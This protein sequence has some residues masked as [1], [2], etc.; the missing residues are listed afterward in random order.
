MKSFVS[1][2]LARAAA[3]A[4]AA[5]LSFIANV[6][7]SIPLL[8]IG[9]FGLR[10]TASAPKRRDRSLSGPLAVFMLSLVLVGI[11]SIFYHLSPSPDRLFWDRLPIAICLAAFACAAAN[12]YRESGIG[13]ALLPYALVVAG[14]SVVYL[15]VTWLRGHADL[16][17]Y[18]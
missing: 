2:R 13:S 17:F 18:A 8:L 4:I 3:G 11:G 16:A 12:I 15:Y 6:M 5:D 9:I 1:L 14:S 10:L 7:T